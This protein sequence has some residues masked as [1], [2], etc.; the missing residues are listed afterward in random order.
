MQVRALYSIQARKLLGGISRNTIYHLLRTE[1]L[2]SVP[3]GSPQFISA[4][5]IA[6]LSARSTTTVSPSR[7]ATRRKPPDQEA[8]PLPPT[9]VRA[10]I[11]RTQT[12]TMHLREYLKRPCRQSRV[13]GAAPLQA[14]AKCSTDLRAC[15]TRLCAYSRHAMMFR[16]PSR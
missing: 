10:R 16:S 14:V 2:D 12:W 7:A 3:I 1:Q 9:S 8:L 11:N 15:N 5:A 13:K 6:D 4:A